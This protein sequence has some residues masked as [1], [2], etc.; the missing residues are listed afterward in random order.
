[1]SAVATALAHASLKIFSEPV[2]YYRM[3]PVS[4]NIFASPDLRSRRYRN[5]SLSEQA[6]IKKTVSSCKRRPK[7]AMSD[8]GLA[9]LIRPTFHF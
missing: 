7:V 3:R 1:L 4:K 8:G 9:G 5:L 6:T 2:A